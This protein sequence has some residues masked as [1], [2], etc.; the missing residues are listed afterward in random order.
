M[1]LLS[2]AS[3]N[4]TIISDHLPISKQL[5]DHSIKMLIDDDHPNQKT[6]TFK[7]DYL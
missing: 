7:S 1:E 2:T 4:S 5:T 3:M 6:N